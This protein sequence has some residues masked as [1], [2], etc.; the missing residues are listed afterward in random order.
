MIQYRLSQPKIDPS[1]AAKKVS[2]LSPQTKPN[3]NKQI[4]KT[5]AA[6]FRKLALKL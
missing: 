5:K 2:I 4:N 3:Q 6:T 1:N